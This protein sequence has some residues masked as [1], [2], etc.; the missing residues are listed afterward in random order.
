MRNCSRFNDQ[1]LAHSITLVERLIKHRS[2]VFLRCMVSH[3]QQ[4]HQFH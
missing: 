2:T 1:L 4:E 3:R